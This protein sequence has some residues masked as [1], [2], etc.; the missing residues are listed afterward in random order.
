MVDT[1]F[2]EEELATVALVDTAVIV[3]VTLVKRPPTMRLMS[4]TLTS[5]SSTPRPYGRQARSGRAWPADDPVVNQ[6][7]TARALR[8]PRRR[9]APGNARGQTCRRPGNGENDHDYE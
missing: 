4:M 5:M 3:S 1:A 8:I 6:T 7:V 9:R 2:L